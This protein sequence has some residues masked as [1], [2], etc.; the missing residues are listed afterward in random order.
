[1]N[2]CANGLLPYENLPGRGEGAYRF[3]RIRK[4]D[5][6]AFLDKYRSE[7]RPTIKESSQDAAILSSEKKKTREKGLILLPGA[8]NKLKGRQLEF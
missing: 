7:L 1:M 5:L 6:D 3:R 8:R 4:T 2:W